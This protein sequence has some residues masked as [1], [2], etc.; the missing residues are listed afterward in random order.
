V[1]D[2]PRHRGRGALQS[3]EPVLTDLNPDIS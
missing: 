3:G 2:Y 1:R